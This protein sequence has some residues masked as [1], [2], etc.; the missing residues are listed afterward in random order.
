MVA[1]LGDKPFRIFLFSTGSACSELAVASA[2]TAPIA[3]LSARSAARQDGLTGRKLHGPSGY[4]W[5]KFRLAAVP[6]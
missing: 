2:S 4:H 1:D 3:M 5:Q 6:N